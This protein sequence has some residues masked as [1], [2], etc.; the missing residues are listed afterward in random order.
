MN[1]PGLDI[2]EFNDFRIESTLASTQ[3]FVNDELVRIDT[4]DLAVEPQDF[5]LNIN[6]QGPA[7]AAAFSSLLQPTADPSLNE[8]FIFEID[9]L[10]IAEIAPETPVIGPR[11]F[12]NIINI[13]SDSNLGDFVDIGDFSGLT[14]TQLN[15]SDGGSVGNNLS[16]FNGSEVNVSGGTVG[17]GLLAFDGSVVN[18]S[19]GTIDDF[20]FATSGSEINISGGATGSLFG[21]E[22][23]E[24]NLFGSEFLLNGLSLDDFLIAD[25]AFTITDRGDDLILSG[26]LADGTPFSYALDFVDLFDADL[27]LEPGQNSFDPDATLTITLVSAVPEPSSLMLLG[28]GG[29]MLLGR[30]RK[31]YS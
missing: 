18:V 21:L 9:S 6:A 7:F 17:I 30:R 5:R 26:L 14:T 10:V 13:P 27:V 20:L 4:F 1:V 8:T 2:T 22:G 25:E 29:V 12:D 19:G 3:F 11:G 16:V 24:I 23:S 15:V 28:I 31:I